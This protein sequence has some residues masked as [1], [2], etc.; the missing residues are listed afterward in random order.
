MFVTSS[1][2]GIMMVAMSLYI[3]PQLEFIAD[4]GFKY[5]IVSGD[6]HEPIFVGDFVSGET[7]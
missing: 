1:Y 4:H 7:H 3:G 5:F 2:A 6:E